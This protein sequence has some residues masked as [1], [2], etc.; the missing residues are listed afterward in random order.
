MTKKQ[1]IDKYG[2]YHTYLRISLTDRCNLSCSYCTPV[3]GLKLSNRGDQLS[4]NE[5]VR[6]VGIASEFGINKIRFTGGE[7]LLRLDIDKIIGEVKH[8]R[9]IE[10]VSI[11][12]NGVLLKEKVI[13]LRDAG[14][15]SLNISLDSL[16]PQRF[17][18]I[19]GRYAF[20]SVMAGIFAAIDYGF[21]P[22]INVVASDSLSFDEADRF[23]EFASRHPVTVRF[24]ELMPLCGEDSKK[25]GF[26]PV[27]RIEEHLVRKHG[28]VNP[29]MDGVAKVYPLGSNSA[30]GFIAPISHP[31]CDQCNRLRLSPTGTLYGCLFDS[32][33]IN[34][35]YMLRNVI[36]D[37]EIIRIF[38]DVLLFKKPS[39]GLDESNLKHRSPDIKNLIRLIGG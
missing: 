39:H 11:T 4:L 7:P 37:E 23:L 32:R 12:T 10:R 20:N 33:G 35:R 8:V 30:V 28:L 9:G 38:R 22:K 36:N 27:N 2:R 16:D 5:I 25:R 31:F 26:V 1:N 3:H 14:L 18:A 29:H 15:D 34:I 6:A 21:V 13:A 24:I 17:N 19:T